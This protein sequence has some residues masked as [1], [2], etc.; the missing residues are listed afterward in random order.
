MEYTRVVGTGEYLAN[1]QGGSTSLTAAFGPAA[2]NGG[3]RF[4]SRLAARILCQ[5]PH[6]KVMPQA[7]IHVNMRADTDVRQRRLRSG[8][9]SY[10]NTGADDSPG[11][12]NLMK[13]ELCF[14]EADHVR[15]Q[16]AIPALREQNVHGTEVFT[17]F[18]QLPTGTKLAFQ[19][20]VLAGYHGGDQTTAAHDVNPN[21]SVQV[22]GTCTINNTSKDNISAGDTLYWDYPDVD[23]NTNQ[24]VLNW[25]NAKPANKFV[26]KVVAD[27]FT[28]RIM[29]VADA[30]GQGTAS[31][32]DELRRKLKINGPTLGA[33]KIL[34]E[35]YFRD[36]QAI[37]QGTGTGR[38]EATLLA[39]LVH[40]MHRVAR[41][42]KIGTACS[43]AIKGGSLDI[44]V[45][46]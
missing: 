13:G 17:A 10:F 20:I 12:Y 25:G 39:Q 46:K 35:S 36:K 18:N 1:M 33:Y 30:L 41:T 11:L 28:D 9:V 16:S 44:I 14:T 38:N 24:P 15:R 3:R 34:L 19:G 31:S 40:D 2:S 32:V 23:E 4:R 6:P 8:A 21:I 37:K 42:R 26:A 29:D 22:G 45:L 7:A 5:E 43:P 27:K